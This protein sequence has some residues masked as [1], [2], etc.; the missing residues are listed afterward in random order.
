MSGQE[1]KKQGLLRVEGIKKSF[2]ETQIL[3][4]ID[5]SVEKGEFITI[6]GSSGCGKTTLLRIIAGLETADEGRIF[7]NN[8]EV[9]GDEPHKRDVRMVFQNYALFPHMNVEANIGYSLRLK[10]ASRGKIKQETADALN[11]VQL[12]GYEKRMPSELSGGQRQRVALARALVNKPPLLLLD[13]PLGALDLQLRRQMQIELKRIQQQ[14]GI[15]FIYITHDQ[16]EALTMSDRIA[17]MRHG[18]FEQLGSA[19]DIYNLPA[20]SYVARFVGN[21]N[22]LRGKLISKEKA[23]GKTILGI[24]V[25][26]STV[27]AAIAQNDS[28][29]TFAI[30]NP[31]EAAAIAIRTEHVI[32]SPPGSAGGQG[33]LARITARSFTGGQLRITAVLKEGGEITA[34]RHGMD[35]P[36]Q[37]GEEVFANW[38][39]PEDAILVEDT[40]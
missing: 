35:S 9:S 27:K 29:N 22:I 26:G 40:E 24:E 36:L 25:S 10:H 32:L 5:L 16:E 39:S 7:L 21:A 2:G 6:L 8:R 37:I 14:L 23:D 11:L 33:L 18:F 17:V 30:P 4:G 20:T 19:T 1:L 38:A 28:S 31:G 3:R 12:H 15:T 13:E 34:S